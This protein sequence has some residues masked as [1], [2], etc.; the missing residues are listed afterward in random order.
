MNIVRERIAI[1][2]HFLVIDSPI[3]FDLIA[4]NG[5]DTV[6]RM[7][8]AWRIDLHKLLPE[9]YFKQYP[10]YSIE[11][12]YDSDL[13]NGST[14]S[15]S[16]SDID[17]GE[18]IAGVNGQDVYIT[19][20]ADIQNYIPKKKLIFKEFTYQEFYDYILD[21]GLFDGNSGVYSVTYFNFEDVLS[22]VGYKSGADS[23]VYFKNPSG[24]MRRGNTN[25]SM[26]NIYHTYQDDKV[27]IRY[28]TLNSA[29]FTNY[30]LEGYDF[31]IHMY[32]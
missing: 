8:G 29:T 1:H 17:L 20:L 3:P 6:H 13:L 23:I 18:G 11:I 26:G 16:Q 19:N 32:E 14:I 10:V 4:N 5:T 24:F 27:Y 2:K 15:I 21:N 30:N 22:F 28:N 25:Y 7:A 9:E 31:E 12:E